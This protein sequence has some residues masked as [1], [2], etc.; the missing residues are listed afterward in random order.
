MKRLAAFLLSVFAL[1]LVTEEAR[2]TEYTGD[3]GG[4]D[5]TLQNGDSLCDQVWNVGTLTIAGGSTVT[6]CPGVALGVTASS[7]VVHGTLDG[8]KAGHARRT[9]AGRGGDGL[10]ECGAWSG[11]PPQCIEPRYGGGGG[12]GYG[13]AGGKGGGVEA[14][15]GG[16]YFGSAAD[17]T[18]SL[19]SGGGNGANANSSYGYGGSGG[20]SIRLTAG[21][22]TIDGAI[23]A[24]GD[25]GGSGDS[26]PLTRSGAGGGGS[27]GTILL[28]GTVGG[29]GHLYARGGAGGSA[30]AA[31]SGGGG[32]GGGGRVKIFAPADPGFCKST[33]VSGGARGS[34]GSDAGG[35]AAADGSE[36]SCRHVRT[37]KTVTTTTVASDKNPVA[38]GAPVTFTAQVTAVLPGTGTPSGTVTFTDDGAPLGTGTINASGLAA[39]TTGSLSAGTH[40]IVAAY[41]GDDGFLASTSAALSVG[42]SQGAVSV[43]LASSPNPSKPGQ[44][45][46][47]TA[48]VSGSSGMATGNVTFTAG[49]ATLGTSSLSG[50]VATLTTKTLSP[51][52]HTIVATYGGDA[53]YPSGSKGTVVHGVETSNTVLTVT[54]SRNPSAVG[55]AVTF[56]VALVSNIVDPTG[57]VELLDGAASLGTAALVADPSDPRQATATLTTTALAL[58]AHPITALYAGDATHGA[59]ASEPL[60]QTVTAASLPDDT[61]KGNEPGK[62]GSSSVVVDVPDPGD[63]LSIE[64]G[65]AVDGGCRMTQ[66]SNAGSFALVPLVGL[67]LLALRRR[68]A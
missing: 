64:G 62:G 1:V 15:D 25:A 63:D 16:G 32:G 38:L 50:G 44:D 54:S 14:G 3:Q 37:G 48:T 20:G 13:G 21:V 27:G 68:R 61:E 11:W 55:E 43:T 18:G 28:E 40:S 10:Y 41:G 39:F 8:S 35:S 53:K 57:A 45:V 36:G 66:G 4:A 17:H 34:T 2:A 42:V 52:S 24:D 29:T 7:V 60:T 51:G 5:L 6:V 12:G 47:F 67:A 59:G 31:S 26:Q 33:T 65:G 56:T 46:V 58:G 22:I 9:G 19:G 23:H 49:G 30:G